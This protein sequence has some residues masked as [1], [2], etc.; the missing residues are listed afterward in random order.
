MQEVLQK[1][2]ERMEQ[3][4]KAKLSVLESKASEAWKRLKLYDRVRAGG[5]VEVPNRERAPGEYNVVALDKHGRTWFSLRSLDMYIE[6]PKTFEVNSEMIWS[7]VMEGR[8]NNSPDE[9][10]GQVDQPMPATEMKE[11]LAAYHNLQKAY[12]TADA[13]QFGKASGTFLQTIEEVSSKFTSYPGTTTIER[14]QWFNRVNP[15]QKAWIVG[16]VAMF[17]LA[18]S[19]L[20]S[21]RWVMASKGLYLLGLAAYLGTLGCA[22][23]GFYC[24]V[25][26]SDR[27]PVS[28]MYESI[29]W[30][31][32]MT[33][34]FGL[35]L[36]LIYRKGVIALAGAVVSTVGFVLADQ[37]PLTFPPGIQPLQA[38][39]RSQ[40]WLIIH[41]LTIVSSYAAFALAWGLGN[42]NLFTIVFAPKRQ[43]LIKTMSLFCYRAI[44]IGA[45][46]LFAGTML[47]G[48]WAAESWGRF[49]GWDPKEVWALIAFL[50]YMIPLHARYVGWIKDFGLAAI[51]VLCFAFV[52]MAWYGV[53]FILGAGLHSY[54]FGAGGN[55]W[56]YMAGLMNIDLVLLAGLSYLYR[57]DAAA[58]VGRLFGRRAAVEA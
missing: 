36:E 5:E 33:A 22:L 41:V 35:I 15:F 19:V 20:F 12:R 2:G 51:S 40:Y 48:A 49:W 53:N 44:Q 58:I 7:R 3:N 46:M 54:G 38:V 11:V 37:L 13:D 23:A 21:G 42:F 29:I 14:E 28:N 6:P 32:F 30:V 56:I 16:V 26:I 45:M 27:P 50:A 18:V 17:L 47:G 24:R 55:S 43:D 10:A 31:A 52:V 34:I 1:V 4:P 57:D 9:Y 39:L 8:R 25:T